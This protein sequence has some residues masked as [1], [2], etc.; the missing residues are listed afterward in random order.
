MKIICLAWGLF[1][2]CLATAQNKKTVPVSNTNLYFE[3]RDTYFPGGEDAWKKLIRE[4]LKLDSI[5][6][7]VLIYDT[8]SWTA[9]VYFTI[10]TSGKLKITE[11]KTA[12][13]VDQVY[14]A[15][16][17]RF[18]E[19]S[20]RWVPARQNGQNIRAMKKQLIGYVPREE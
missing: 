10:D 18:F 9:D 6:F 3:E 15:E 8:L 4:R 19:E 11:I 14:L 20:P 12:F 2:S 5:H 7:D 13:A 17:R 1:F 16:I